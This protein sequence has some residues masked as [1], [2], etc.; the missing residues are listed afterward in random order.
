MSYFLRETPRS[1]D[2]EPETQTVRRALFVCS[3]GGHLDQLCAL[4][5]PPEGTEVIFATFSKPDAIAKTEGYRAYALYWPTN[6]SVKALI[7]NS[8]AAIRILLSVRPDV[9]VSSGAAV[10]VPFFFLS[11]IIGRP[12]TIYVEC[13]DRVRNPTLTARLVKH[14]TDTFIVQYTD[15][16]CEFP[17]RLLIG[18]SR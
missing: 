8:A 15:Q 1:I 13:I 14:V 5:P 16:L 10:A 18:L 17:N 7:I 2:A 11:R 6:R 3:S 12:Q 9:L 4:L